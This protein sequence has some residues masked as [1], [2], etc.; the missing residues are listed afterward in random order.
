[1]CMW[2][3][4]PYFVSFV[5]SKP[6]TKVA[7]TIDLEES[8]DEVERIFEEAAAAQRVYCRGLNYCQ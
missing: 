5:S 2:S 8:I 4:G 3:L 6:A 1:M 7:E